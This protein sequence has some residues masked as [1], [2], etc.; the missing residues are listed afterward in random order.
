[1]IQ[2][3]ANSSKA[4]RT[5]SSTVTEATLAICNTT[6]TCGSDRNP[7]RTNTGPPRIRWS[8]PTNIW[9]DR[10]SNTDRS[11]GGKRKHL[12][13]ISIIWNIWKAASKPDSITWNRRKKNLSFSNSVN[14]KTKKER[15]KE[16]WCKSQ[17]RLPRW[18]P[19]VDLFCLPTR[20][21][22]GYGTGRM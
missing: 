3:Q 16:N 17:C 2:R 15:K 6:C 1:M 10:P 22:F 11:K 18:I 19:G 5:L 8:K 7:H 20:L 21:P 4:I 14:G 13:T 9:A 12:S